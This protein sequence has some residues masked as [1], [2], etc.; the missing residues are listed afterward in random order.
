MKYIKKPRLINALVS[1]SVFA[2]YLC[3]AYRAYKSVGFY[4]WNFQ[5]T[6]PTANVSPFM[7]S[8]M[9]LSWILSGKAKEYFYRLIT[10]LSFGMLCSAILSCG[11]NAA[12]NYA[13]HF[14]FLADYLA[15]II[16]SLWG[17]YLV[18]SKQVS[19][20]PCDSV[21]SGSLIVGTAL[22]ML[23]LNV[24]FDTSFF[25][26]SLN[27]KHSIYN[28]VLVENSALSAVLY[29]SGLVGVLILGYAFNKILNRKN[30]KGVKTG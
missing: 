8:L 16:L 29:I 30:E 6:L 10:L 13:F 27:G 3:V 17:V 23:V 26:L 14:S 15:H 20:R 22:V 4:D 28:V 7:F 5:N 1:V 24:I 25:G 11:F 21:V 9:P 12:R 2:L 18:R 19:L